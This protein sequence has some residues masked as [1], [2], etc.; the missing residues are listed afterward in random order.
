MQQKPQNHYEILG[1]SSDASADD[2]KK[3]FKALI[4]KWHPDKNPDKQEEANEKTAALNEAY[5][6]LKDPVTRKQYD[7]TLAEI[8]QRVYAAETQP[9][10]SYANSSSSSFDKRYPPRTQHSSNPNKDADHETYGAS[11]SPEPRFQKYPFKP[12]QHV[13]NKTKNTNINNDRIYVIHLA[14]VEILTH[15]IKPQPVKPHTFYFKLDAHNFLSLLLETAFSSKP[16]SSVTDLIK[17][18]KENTDGTYTVKTQDPELLI[19]L[20]TTSTLIN[21]LYLNAEINFLLN[22]TQQEAEQF[23][24]NDTHHS[25]PFNFNAN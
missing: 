4:L 16:T 5:N 2:I 14:S 7:A 6:T 11:T 21:L 25:S 17:N 1:V 22:K 20:L 8:K 23:S 18:A 12:N 10:A 24:N 15:P 3:A 19:A 13:G 9:N